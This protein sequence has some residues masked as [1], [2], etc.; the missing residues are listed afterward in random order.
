MPLFFN[1]IK[2]GGAMKFIITKTAKDFADK[3]NIR[4]IYINPDIDSKE[5]CCTIGTVDFD[6]S[7]KLIGNKEAYKKFSD[8]DIDIFVNPNFF[9][10]VKDDMEIEISAFGIGLFKK[11]YIKTEINTIER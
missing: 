11:L 10:F 4:E 6:V 3:K 5:T 8:Q 2:L 1:I 9:S 7:T